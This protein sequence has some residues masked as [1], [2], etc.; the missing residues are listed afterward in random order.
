MP[1]ETTAY[2]PWREKKNEYQ[3]EWREKNKDYPREWHKKNKAETADLPMAA[4]SDRDNPNN[5]RA[6]LAAF[7]VMFI[8]KSFIL[9]HFWN[10]R[11]FS[12]AGLKIGFNDGSIFVIAPTE[13]K[14][15]VKSFFSRG[16]SVLLTASSRPSTI[17]L[18]CRMYACSDFFDR[19][20][21]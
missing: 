16:F 4:T 19:Q 6:A 21:P 15:F 11:I 9:C 12:I 7:C 14:T 3:R 17:S 20:V 8:C 13:N 18:Y 1:E 5:A 2:N 10:A